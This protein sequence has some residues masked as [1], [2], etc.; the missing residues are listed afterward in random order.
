MYVAFKSLVDMSLHYSLCP[1]L[2]AQSWDELFSLWEKFEGSL[3][4]LQIDI[5][6]G[7]FAP[8]VSWPFTEENGVSA[9]T[10]ARLFAPT[11]LEIDCMCMHPETY[12]DTFVSI[13]VERV[14][15]HAESTEAYDVCLSHRREHGYR[16]GL[17]IKNTTPS[18]LVDELVPEF[19]YVQVMGIA[20]IGA[21]GQPFDERTLDTIQR[22]RA[23]YPS[24]EI[25]VDGA[26]N[27]ETIPNLREA[28]A[29]RFA[30]GSAISKSSD[31]VLAYK[32]LLELL[33]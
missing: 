13:P 10:R 11:E 24:L 5:V 8:F 19:D 4:E 12:L 28:G 3:P 20:T 18:A 30:P 1:S 31:S 25:A 27:G 17:G 22:L 33:S 9:I 23:Q 16:M 7:V 32:Q 6:D 14:V 15:I 21:Q 26:V 2:P 29:N